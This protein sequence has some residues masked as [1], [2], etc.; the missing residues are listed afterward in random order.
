MNKTL[1]VAIAMGFLVGSVSMGIAGQGMKNTTGEKNIPDK[2]Q[3]SA[4]SGEE[5]LPGGSGPGSRSSDLTGMEEVNPNDHISSKKAEANVPENIQR[6]APSG[7]KALPGGSGP[8]SRTDQL[9]GMEEVEPMDPKLSGKKGDAAQAAK[10]LK[11]KSQ[12]KS[13]S[14]QSSSKQSHE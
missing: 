4:P 10:D 13:I 14:S 11:K 5:S 12:E 8:G 6:S 1:Q 9:T 3:R 2:I 7:E